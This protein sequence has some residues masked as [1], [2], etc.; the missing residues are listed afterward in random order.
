MR[1]A[2]SGAKCSCRERIGS[3]PN[4]VLAGEQRG[5]VD[6]VTWVHTSHVVVVYRKKCL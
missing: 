3:K 4:P 6:L 1:F 5:E 2:P